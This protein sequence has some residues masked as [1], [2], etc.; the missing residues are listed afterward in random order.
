[1][2][3]KP[4]YPVEEEWQCIT[5]T[6]RLSLFL[7]EHLL[8]AILIMR[9]SYKGA[10]QNMPDLVKLRSRAQVT[11]PKAAIKKLKLKEGDNLSVEVAD[12]KVIITPVAVIPRDELWA[13][14]PE[15]RGI[16]EQSRL[17]AKEGN[18]KGY[19]SVEE[20]WQD[21]HVAESEADDL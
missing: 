6:L 2:E 15:M 17:E 18:L 19:D 1:M 8:S 20:L 4:G 11:L 10:I 16:I 14:S 12:G 7:L 9:N 5:R 21:L 13:W 3:Y